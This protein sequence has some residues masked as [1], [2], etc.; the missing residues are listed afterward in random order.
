MNR[1]TLHRLLPLPPLR[2]LCTC[3]NN[4]LYPFCR[5][6]EQLN[7]IEDGKDQNRG[8]IFTIKRYLVSFSHGWT[9]RKLFTSYFH[10]LLEQ[11]SKVMNARDKVTYSFRK[12]FYLVIV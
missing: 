2:S 4:L 7:E 12:S 6:D 5:K 11:G 3:E 9:K 8:H 1:C 10:S